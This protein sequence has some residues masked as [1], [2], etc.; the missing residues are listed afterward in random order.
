M[1]HLRLTSVI[2]VTL[3]LGGGLFFHH[4]KF[5]RTERRNVSE[6]STDAPEYLNAHISDR[7]LAKKVTESL[8]RIEPADEHAYQADNL[9]QRFRTVFNAEGIQI[10]SQRGGSKQVTVRLARVGYGSDLSQISSQPALRVEGSRIVYEYQPIEKRIATK[11]EEW[12]VNQPQGLEQGFTIYEPIN[13]NPDSQLLRLELESSGQLV[14]AMNAA[15]IEFNSAD[16][17]K[18]FRYGDI[19][20]V[21]ANGRVLPSRLSL[22]Q[23]RISCEIDDSEARYPITI[24]PNWTQQT[25]LTASDGSFGD[26]FGSAVSISGDTA[27]VGAAGVLQSTGAVYVFKRTGT[28]WS[29]EQKLTASDGAVGD[30]FG[31]RV[32]IEGDTLIAGAIG[33]SQNQGA[34]YIFVRNGSSW[35]LQKKLTA[36]DGVAQDLFGISVAISTD[37]VVIGAEADVIGAH[38]NQGSAYVFVRSG[39]TWSF[40]QKLIASDGA[41]GDFLGQSVAID[42][43]NVVLGAP[44]VLSDRG[45][46]YVFSRSGATWSQQQKLLANQ[47]TVDVDFGASVDIDGSTL[48]VGG[49]LDDLL[50]Q[51]AV[52]I[53]T[54]SAGV[55]SQEQKLTPSDR[56]ANDNFGN[57]VALQ[58]DLVVCGSSQSLNDHGSAYVF[59][60][61]GSTWSQQQKLTASDAGSSVHLGTSLGI[62][63]HYLIIGAPGADFGSNV[64]QGSAH[65]FLELSPDPILVTTTGDSGRGTLRFAIATANAIPGP[66]IIAF[67]IL[68]SGVHTITPA[69]VLPTITEPVII[70]GT[71]QTGYASSPVIEINGQNIF[72][73]GLNIQ[74]GSSTVK[75]LAI[76]R[77]VGAGIVL[78]GNG[79]NTI[80]NCYLGTDASGTIDR[81]NGTA[82][83][84]I[85]CSNNLIGG[86]TGAFRN[87][88]SGN[89]QNG[90]YV[91]NA[92]STGNTIENNRIGTNASGGAALANGNGINVDLGAS[93]NT[94][95]SNLIAGN[96]TGIRLNGS[97]NTV[98][99]NFLGV[100]SNGVDPIPNTTNILIAGSNNAIGTSA[101]DK[102]TI[103]FS[104]GA[105]VA[106]TGGLG[107]SIRFNSI[108]SNSGLGIDLGNDGVTANDPSDADTGPN[109]LVNYP[110]I[111]SA[112]TAGLGIT[113]QGALDSSPQAVFTLDFYWS[114]SGD[115]S[116]FGEGQNYIGSRMVLTDDSGN[117]PFSATLT[118]VSVPSGSIITAVTVDASG[119]TSEFSRGAVVGDSS[120]CGTLEVNPTSA[121]PGDAGGSGIVNVIKAAGCNWNA[122]SNANWI[123]ITSGTSGVGNGAVTYNVASNPSPGVARTGTMTIGGQTVTVYQSHGPTAV[124]DLSASVVSF[125]NGTLIEWRTGLEVSN[126]GFNLYKENFGKRELINKQLVAGSAL[127][128]GSETVMSAGRSYSW[129]DSL[130]G[131]QEPCYRL[132]AID[133]NGRSS[134]YGPFCSTR[135]DG[136]LEFKNQSKTIEQVGRKAAD[137]E[138]GTRALESVASMAPVTLSSLSRQASIESSDAIKI[139]VRR[140]GWYRLTQP[141]LVRAGLNPKL[142]PQKFHLYAG[143]VEQPILVNGDEDGSFDQDDSIEFYSVALDTPATDTRVYW[144]TSNDAA[145]KR[146][147]VSRSAGKPGGAWSFPYTV[148]RKDRTIYFSALL[149]GE[150]ENFFG[151]IVFFQPLDQTITVHSI[152]RDATSKAE[153]EVSL[154]GVTDLPSFPDHYVSVTFNGVVIGHVSFDG[155]Q[156]KTERFALPQSSLID[157]PNRIILTGEG[158]SADIS[159]VDR[160]RLTYAHTFTAE[161]NVIKVT[162]PE[163]NRSQTIS[164]FTSPD[165]RV[166][167]VTDPLETTQLTGEIEKSESGY[168]VTVGLSGAGARQ[169]LALT[170]E[171]VLEPL[172]V[173]RD[174]PSLLRQPGAG[175]DLVVIT[176]EELVPSFELL[177][178][179]RRSQGLSSLVVNVEDIY[180]EFSFGVKSPQAIKDF[181]KYAVSSW[182]RKPRFVLFG[183]DASYDPRNYLGFEDR[184]RVPTHLIDTSILETASDDWFA[185]FDDDGLAELAV[186]RLPARTA[187]EA[188]VMVAKLIS[189]DQIKSSEEALVVADRDDGFGF[190][191]ESRSIEP[192]LAGL[193]VNEIF[194]SRMDDGTARERVLAAI[195]RGQKVVNYSGH[196]SAGSWRGDLLTVND[197]LG[198]ENS[199]LSVFTMMNCL[200]GYF[201]DP[202]AESLG[203]SLIKAP[204]GGAVAVWASSGMTLAGS[205]AG[206]EREFYR[207]LSLHR[208]AIG[209]VIRKAKSATGDLDVRRTWVLLGDPSM[210]IR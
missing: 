173:V 123:V 180:D 64:Q 154:Q 39:T 142:D 19:Y 196:G 95:S 79:D 69:T 93:T 80:Q 15:A 44:G 23:N 169:L 203:E 160:V 137:S 181:L 178:S 41:Q 204:R 130:S 77:F 140:E 113:I 84:S 107:N 157:G 208:D 127:V 198:L 105:G 31:I 73:S 172:S 104:G 46:A 54:K 209:D 2:L 166:F 124:Q 129:F 85:G 100:S 164:G 91:L 70:D 71:T 72:G 24:D 194:R 190:E 136:V 188:S 98:I 152:D 195:N 35:S 21:D 33:D 156:N 55:W 49:P 17:E 179:H 148:E 186:G 101:I 115:A 59:T 114:S 150:A 9:T 177:A 184:N 68:G 158:G 58:G 187:D 193:R 147:N 99:R 45:A 6:L 170:S 121:S 82:G 27:V 25:V 11:I 78:S 67:D 12:Y 65:I 117:T 189:Y 8:Y 13:Q 168:R 159:L 131:E 74:A 16:G 132:E 38:I 92:V 111:T 60:R 210:K 66:D 40:Q 201:H 145:G 191:A 56:A 97:S 47:N 96:T 197:A 83:I 62:D 171:C 161:T 135:S 175:A 162:P 183:G 76:N 32:A 176:C 139:S 202:T 134:W 165:I 57:A 141:D 30:K 88:I 43:D 87:I 37:T 42:G 118:P 125:N 119:N 120:T 5:R 3:A 185:D 36:S 153:L 34:A 52:F 102:N 133:T 110:V 155:R 75:A 20:A 109:N 144:L 22:E 61:S 149:N 163:G 122:L 128:A 86:A 143:G 90:I 182:K 167:D 200:N 205:Q 1:K 4:L 207:L 192:L 106:V 14:P 146:I 151:P 199:S 29:Q 112:N 50:D 206:L 26:V 7:P 48:A 18:C 138:Q 63:G 94:I 53:F 108:N 81:G 28:S 126:L 116:G 10:S 174:V 103:V 89:T 51:G